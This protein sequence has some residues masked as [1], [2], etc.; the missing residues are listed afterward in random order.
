MFDSGAAVRR[1]LSLLGSSL[2]ALEAGPYEVVVIG[3]A[4]LAVIGTG[5]RPTKD[6]DVLGL[7]RAPALRSG[8]AMEVG[9][10]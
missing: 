5:I 3:G 4:A 10:G 8:P 1:A 9:H 6:V 7:C 2:E